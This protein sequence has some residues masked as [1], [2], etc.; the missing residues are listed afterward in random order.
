MKHLKLLVNN[1]LITCD[2]TC[3]NSGLY[4]GMTEPVKIQFDF[5]DDWNERVKVAAFWSVSG[6]EYDPQLILSD[7]TC[8]VPPEAL[9]GTVFKVQVFGKLNGEKI[10][11]GKCSVYLRGGKP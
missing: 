2:P 6:I 9:Q 3:R 1:K 10:S 8:I 4:M 7:N 11:T 5:S